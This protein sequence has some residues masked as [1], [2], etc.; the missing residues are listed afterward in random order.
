[1]K[2]TVSQEDIKNTILSLI[3]ANSGDEATIELLICLG[4]ELLNIN[5]EEA[6]RFFSQEV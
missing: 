6:E 5:R 4:A 1:M 3:A 2:Q